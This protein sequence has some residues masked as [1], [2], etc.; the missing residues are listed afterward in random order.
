MKK[1][2]HRQDIAIDLTSLLD[3][4]FIVLL[5]VMG[6]QRL[7]AENAKAEAAQAA[8]MMDQTAQIQQAYANHIQKYEE[9]EEYVLFIDVTAAY[10]SAQ[11]SRRTIRVMAGA[12][13]E[14]TQPYVIEISTENASAGFQELENVLH[15]R[16]EEYAAGREEGGRPVILTLNKKDDD[17]LYRD[18]VVIKAIFDRIVEQYDDVY[19]R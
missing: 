2:F 6:N 3:V 7:Q 18:E 14:K 11:I 10:S 4:I 13:L 12:D 16:I 19:L 1:L 5:I 17:I 8:E 15:S 9:T